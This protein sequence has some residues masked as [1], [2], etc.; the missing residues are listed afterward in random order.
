M[1][2]GVLHIVLG[3]AVLLGVVGLWFLFY[4]LLNPHV[5]EANAEARIKGKCGDTMEI[6]LR[7]E[8]G[9]VLESSYWTDGCVYSL[10]AVFAAADLAKGK[11]PDEILE[12]DAGRIEQ[13]MGGLPNDHKHCSKLAEETLQAALHD[14]M[15]RQ[16]LS[17]EDASEKE[18][19]KDTAKDC[20]GGSHAKTREP[21]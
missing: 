1:G 17:S 6:R 11:V 9:K 15:T 14:Y 8:N 20:R 19:I 21:W 7:F 4:Y 16:G 2:Q 12:I 10:N 5:K 3:L 18:G 13:S